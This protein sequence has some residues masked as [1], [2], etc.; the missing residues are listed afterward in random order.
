MT[1]L[2]R[3]PLRAASIL[4]CCLLVQMHVASN[5]VDAAGQGRRL[6]QCVQHCNALLDSCREACTV[7]CDLLFPEG[8]ER[9]RC[10]SSCRDL[11][12]DESH[13]CK[14][15]CNVHRIPPSGVEP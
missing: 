4:A 2:K 13:D 1:N 12:V 9:N 5:F 8:E 7:D 14:A 3:L 6:S 11:C 10:Q 15:R